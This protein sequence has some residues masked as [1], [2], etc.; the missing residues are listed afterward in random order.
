MQKRGYYS[1][2]FKLALPIMLSSLGQ[3][4][5]QMVDTLMIGQLGTVPLAAVSFAFAM[6]Y[7]AFVIGMGIAM[8]LTPLTG[9]N[10]A[11]GKKEILVNLFENSLSLNTLLSIVLVG[12]LLLLLPFLHLLGQPNEVVERCRPYYIMVALSFIPMMCFLTFK[13]FF[14]GLGNT[15]IAMIITISSNILNIF[16]N[17]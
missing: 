6:T 12:I 10:Y 8:A 2:N 4:L 17:F 15:K 5:V 13:Q 16:L 14:E 11:K 3:Q 1:Q 9:Q 7:N